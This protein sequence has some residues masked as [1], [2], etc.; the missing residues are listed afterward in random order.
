[1]HIIMYRSYGG[2]QVTKE[3]SQLGAEAKRKETNNLT[4][5]K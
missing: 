1:M 2:T 5:L 3:L 4:E